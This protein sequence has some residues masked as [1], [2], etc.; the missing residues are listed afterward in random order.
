V[1]WGETLLKEVGVKVKEVPCL[2]CDN[3]GAIYSYADPIFHARTKHIEIDFH[4]VRERESSQQA[5]GADGLQSP[6]LLVD[7]KSLSIISTCPSYN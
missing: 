3:M 4:F 1:I 2:W 6:F 5:A 7:L